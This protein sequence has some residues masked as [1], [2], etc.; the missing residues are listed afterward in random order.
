MEQTEIIMYCVLPSLKSMQ[1]WFLAWGV[2]VYVSVYVCVCACV[3]LCVCVCM[4]VCV[5]GWG[6]V[7][8]RA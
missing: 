7:A 6:G 5:V 8:G 3:C 4:C 1:D 2:G